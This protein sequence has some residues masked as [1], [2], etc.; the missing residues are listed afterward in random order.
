MGAPIEL[1]LIRHLA[2]RLAV[3]VFVVDRAGDLVF[4]NEPAEAVLG[5]RFEEIRS[6]PFDDWTTAF[7]PSD[8]QAIA[9][10]DL[11]LVVALRRGVPAHR[12]FGIQAADGARRTIEATAFPL[13]ATG[14]DIVGAVAMFWEIGDR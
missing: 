6:M 14:G 12:T 9:V 10:D 7:L 2:S 8:D 5:E 1:I 4:F 3:P 13:L 11:P